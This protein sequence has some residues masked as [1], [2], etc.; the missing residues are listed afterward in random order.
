MLVEGYVGLL[1]GQT[2]V[3]EIQED[4]PHDEVVVQTCAQ[5]RKQGFLVS[6]DR[7]RLSRSEDPLVPQADVLKVDFRTTPLDE[8][9]ACAQRLRRPGLLLLADKVETRKELTEAMD[10]GYS[11]YQG[12]FFCRPEMAS[13]KDIPAYKLNYL[14]FLNEVNREECDFEVLEK[15]IRQ[16][17]ALSLKL[18]RYINSAMFSLESRVDS[19]RQAL[20]LVGLALMK[21]WASLL[22]LAAMADDRPAE[23][24]V[25]SLIRARFCEQV[26]AGA[27]LEARA[28]DLFMIG[29]LSAMDAILDRPMLEILKDLPVSGEV[30]ET[31]MGN[32][33]GIGKI[34]GLA[35][36]YERAEW[37]R[38]PVLMDKLKID[39]LRIPVIYR[40]S[41]SWSEQIFKVVSAA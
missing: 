35:V 8:R 26:G 9:R 17:V 40:E 2:T 39:V 19:I 41:V 11:L 16:D 13:R 29:L 32:T 3:L 37:D 1:P 12:F 14:R 20:A 33:A 24:I 7:F 34:L 23:L 5:L 38:I 27:G 36:A 30:R 6:L 15:I 4:V 25:T 21:R 22:A 10:L 18:L 31:L 28:F